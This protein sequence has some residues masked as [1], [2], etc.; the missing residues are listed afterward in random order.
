[1]EENKLK[2]LLIKIWPTIYRLINSL[3]YFIISLIKSIV[4]YSIK[5]IKGQY[6]L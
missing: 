2:Y 3:I 5:Q 1:M 6:I 4:S